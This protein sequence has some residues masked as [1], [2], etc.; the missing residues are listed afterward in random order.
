MHQRKSANVGKLA[1]EC[2]AFEIANAPAVFFEA[3]QIGVI[4]K[5]A[6]DEIKLLFIIL[7]KD[8]KYRS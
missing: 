6:H 1:S 2:F 8:F 7:S 4:N 3:L 5:L